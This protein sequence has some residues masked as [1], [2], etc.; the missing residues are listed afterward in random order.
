MTEAGKNDE[1]TSVVQQQGKNNGQVGT[2]RLLRK[3]NEIAAKS[4]VGILVG[5]LLFFLELL[6]L[7]DWLDDEGGQRQGGAR[8][9]GA[10]RDEE[11]TGGRRGKGGGV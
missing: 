1:H 9:R 5:R 11:G 2:H 3:A 10:R 7:L 6:E 4:R 8:R